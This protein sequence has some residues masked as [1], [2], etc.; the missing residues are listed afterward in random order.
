VRMKKKGIYIMTLS[1]F[2]ILTLLYA[3]NFNINKLTLEIGFPALM[4]VLVFIYGLTKFITDNF[5][6]TRKKN[7]KTKTD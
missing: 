4:F 1:I 5:W 7:N 6:T 2:A 3:V